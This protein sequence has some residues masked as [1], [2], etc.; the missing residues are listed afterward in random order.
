MG[1]GRDAA[2]HPAVQRAAPATQN[3]LAPNVDSAKV[4]SLDLYTHVYVCVCMRTHAY[5]REYIF[6]HVTGASGF[7]TVHLTTLAFSTLVV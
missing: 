2:P 3:S 6:A 4:A 5:T 7:K 1:R